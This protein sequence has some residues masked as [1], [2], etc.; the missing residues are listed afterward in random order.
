MVTLLEALVDIRGVRPT[1]GAILLGSLISVFL[2]GIVTM[3]V[4]VYYRVY[5]NDRFLFKAL[6]VMIW[7]LDVLHSAMVCASNWYYLVAN[8]GNTSSTDFIPWAVA[9]TIALTAI[10]TFLVHV[11][12]AHRILTR[13]ELHFFYYFAR[14]GIDHGQQPSS[15]P[16]V[17]LRLLKQTDRSPPVT[18]SQSVR[19]KSYV[20]LADKF[21]WAFTLGL[22]IAA[23]IDV[24]IAA[25]LCLY[26]HQSRTGFSSMDGII[27]SI[28]LYTVE[29]GMLT[30]LTTI[31]TLICWLTMRHNLIWLALHFAISKLYA[32]AFMATL[33]ARKVLRGRSKGSSN[34]N[35]HA[36]PVMFPDGSRFS[37]GIT[38]NTRPEDPVATRVT[39]N[40]EKTIHCEGAEIDPSDISL[41]GVQH[42]ASSSQDTDKKDLAFIR[43]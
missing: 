35:D 21:N 40:V 41:D 1:M 17:S 8:F 4:F 18:A 36:M 34:G 31:I 25:A 37:R 29:N 43:V 12:F 5:P 14:H 26:L 11:F 10:I 28:T 9:V 30:C 32:N 16:F 20:L 7:G 22:S 24:V 39:V 33:N 15:L 38:F 42:D 27:D 19:L 23:V 3:Q 2:S 6:V 13:K